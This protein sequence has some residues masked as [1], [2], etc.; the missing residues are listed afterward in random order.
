MPKKSKQYVLFGATGNTG[1]EIL[2]LLLAAGYRVRVL[3]RNPDKLKMSHERL[4]VIV[5][6]ISD[7]NLVI[8]TIKGAHA[9]ISV[10]GHAL[11]D[12]AYKGGMLLPYVKAVHLGMKE[13]GVK[14]L[15]VQSGAVAKPKDESFSILKSL[16]LRQLFSRLSGDHGVHVDN[17]QVLDY[18]ETT[19]SDIDW[20]VT[21]PPG[22]VDDP[23]ELRAVIAL[24]KMPFPPTV[25]F[26][27]LAKYTVE[28]IIDN[29]FIH[30]ANYCGHQK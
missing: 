26:Q 17:D 12:R 11:G 19:A 22:I 5:D 18:L 28:A 16:L 24:K 21:R 1:K 20:I 9:I 23:A 25:T 4:E 3:V 15:L 6:D 14:R 13:H 30:T 7:T 8:N 29:S 27:Q 2:P 10:V